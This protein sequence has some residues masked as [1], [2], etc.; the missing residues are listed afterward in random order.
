MTVSA[1]SVRFPILTRLVEIPAFVDI[2]LSDSIRSLV[3]SRQQNPRFGCGS[4]WISTMNRQ[5]LYFGMV[6]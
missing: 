4:D 2:E 5:F 6:T 1:H 3:S